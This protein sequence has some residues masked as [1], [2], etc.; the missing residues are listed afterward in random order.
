MAWWEYAVY[1]IISDV[2]WPVV[3]TGET[4][5][6]Y[7]PAHPHL[8]WLVERVRWLPRSWARFA[9]RAPVYRDADPLVDHRNGLIYCS[10]AQADALRQLALKE[11]K[12]LDC[13]MRSPR[14]WRRLSTST[15]AMS[16]PC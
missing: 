4:E 1:R 5:L 8:V 15:S 12:W 14:N 7:A 2:R 16:L 6:R 3:A 9:Y 13:S 11:G 10:V